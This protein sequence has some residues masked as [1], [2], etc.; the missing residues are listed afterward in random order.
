MKVVE[1]DQNSP[2][3]LKWREQG[4]GASEAG[5]VL[6]ENPFCTPRELAEIKLGMRVVEENE[7]MS[8]GKRLEPEAR[9][10][11]QNLTGIEVRPV[12]IVHPKH[13]WLRASLDGLSLDGKIALEIKCPGKWPHFNTCKRNKVPSYYFAQIQHQF[14]AGAGKIK[15]IDYFSYR[16]D[17]PDC[18]PCWKIPV[19][20]DKEYQD[21]LFA[22][23]KAFWDELERVKSIDLTKPRED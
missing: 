19:F 9:A 11:Y 13:S 22:R 18:K 10:M 12:C 3:W 7:A 5:A 1:L 17:D 2:E 15:R 23:E 21:D 20:P 8:R 16:P 6:G 4:I 14:M